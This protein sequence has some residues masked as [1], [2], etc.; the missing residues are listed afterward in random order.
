[1]IEYELGKIKCISSNLYLKFLI[2]KLYYSN[3]VHIFTAKN[4]HRKL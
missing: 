4:A 3:V 1:M 2:T